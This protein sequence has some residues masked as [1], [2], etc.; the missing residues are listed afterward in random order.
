MV[1]SALRQSVESGAFAELA[2]AYA[3]GASLDA[4]LSGARR[5]V[6]GPAAI[7]AVLAGVFAGPGR[8]IEWDEATH[9]G[10]VALWLER[11]GDDGRAVRQRHYLHL[12]EGGLIERHWIYT[13][14]PRT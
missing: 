3:P 12:N 10:G 13:A 1:T 4:A 14:R 7:A 5:R 9:D 6:E 2:E 11:V 8:L